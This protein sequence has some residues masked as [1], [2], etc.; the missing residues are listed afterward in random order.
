MISKPPFTHFYSFVNLSPG[1]LRGQI[2]ENIYRVLGTIEVLA[3][4]E[5]FIFYEAEDMH[6]YYS[7]PIISIIIYSIITH[8]LSNLEFDLC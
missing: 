1:F 8:S 5:P 3:A 7:E 4:C 6:P 2:R